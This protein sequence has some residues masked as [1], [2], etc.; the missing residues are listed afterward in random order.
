MKIALNNDYVAGAK[1]REFVKLS[2]KKE[3]KKK[4]S[5]W[6]KKHSYDNDSCPEEYLA[7]YGPWVKELKEDFAYR[8]QAP[9]DIFPEDI[10]DSTKDDLMGIQTLSNG[11]I[12]CGYIIG[13]E[14]HGYPYMYAISY[15]DGTNIRAY[16]PTKGNIINMDFGCPI[17]NELEL[18]Y[19]SGKIDVKKIAEKY[20]DE[21]RLYIHDEDYYTVMLA[22][23]MPKRKDFDNI[24][25]DVSYIAKYAK[26]KMPKKC[27]YQELMYDDFY[28]D[29]I[30]WDL[31]RE[32]I[33][34]NFI[35][36]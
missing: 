17:G 11:L 36:K 1:K 25:W 7:C 23:S 3:F 18:S 32:D 19:A 21:N 12:F 31:I 33:E 2:S 27:D 35:C 29:P 15:Y 9:E 8:F 10:F 28:E 24:A 22:K 30:D 13:G 26:S 16:V 4:V 34:E 6:N 14:G 5:E 20:F